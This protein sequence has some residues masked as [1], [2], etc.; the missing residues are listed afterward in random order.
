MKCLSLWQ[1][2]ASLVAHGKKRVET[3]GWPL[4]YR[5]P[6]LIHAAKK[7]NREM[8]DLCHRVEPFAS[9]LKELGMTTPPVGGQRVQ[10]PTNMPFGEIVGRVDVVEC[11]PVSEVGSLGELFGPDTELVHLPGH[12]KYFS[13][14]IG[15]NERAFGDYSAGRFAILCE[16]AVAFKEPIPYRG[17]QGLFDV[18]DDAVKAAA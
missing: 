14:Q 7:W 13:L 1:P 4:R 17:A 15:R 8:A 9:V 6:L 11:Y 18:P 16:K 2:W 5:G 12:P 3:R 10:T